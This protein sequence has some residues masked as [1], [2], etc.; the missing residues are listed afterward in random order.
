[1]LTIAPDPRAIIFGSSAA[2]RKNGALTFDVERHV[3]RVDV[4]LQCR[5]GLVRGRVVDQHVD[6]TDLETRLSTSARSVGCIAYLTTCSRHIDYFC[7]NC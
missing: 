7:S 6:L 3:K 2:V 1:M 4:L 5:S